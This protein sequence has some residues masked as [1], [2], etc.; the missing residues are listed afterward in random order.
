MQGLNNCDLS[1]INSSNSE[2]IHP[3]GGSKGNS[4]EF[5][6]ETGSNAPQHSK[7][8]EEEKKGEVF[9]EEVKGGIGSLGAQMCGTEARD[10]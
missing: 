4:P 5:N 9:K 2:N 1:L 3:N 7:Y 6:N 8:Y 10:V